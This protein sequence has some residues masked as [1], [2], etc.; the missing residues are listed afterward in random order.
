ISV[1]HEDG[2]NLEPVSGSNDLAYVIYTSG[3]TG[4]PKGVM[5]EHRG[6]CN[7]KMYFDQTLCIGLSDHTML[8]ASYS[9]DVACW[10]IF[11]ALF[12]GATL[13]VP[14]ME[15]ILDYKEF[16][17]YIAEHRITV[18]MLPPTYAVYLE[19]ERM[20]NLRILLTA[21]SAATTELVHKWK[22]S[23]VYYNAYGP[24]EDSIITSFWPLPE[25]PSAGKVI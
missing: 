2:S 18:L 12:C 13:Y 16:E 15:T 23:V 17:Q 21:G 24:T 11:Q 20:S 25:D 3:T 8:F 14:T 19:P 1:Y 4:Q 5:V 7:L 22:D 9:F 10:E 6:L